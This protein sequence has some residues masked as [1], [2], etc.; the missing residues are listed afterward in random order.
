MKLKKLPHHLT[1]CKVADMDDID[2]N[3]E[4]YFI[5][6]TDEELSVVCRTEDTPEKTIDLSL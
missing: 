2:L 1:I 4:F 6:K 5:G 3:S